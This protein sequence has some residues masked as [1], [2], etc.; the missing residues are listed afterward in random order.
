MTYLNMEP[1]DL[2]T[3]LQSRGF[4]VENVLRTKNSLRHIGYCRFSAY[5]S[6]FL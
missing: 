1:N 3:L 6:F 5:Y 2:V 4:H